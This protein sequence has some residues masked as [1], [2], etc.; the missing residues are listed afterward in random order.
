MF[1][2]F[3]N[4]AYDYE[5]QL[6]NAIKAFLIEIFRRQKAKAWNHFVLIDR[7]CK[8]DQSVQMIA[9]L[10]DSG[11]HRSYAKPEGEE[12]SLSKSVIERTTRRNNRQM[13]STNNGTVN[14]KR[15]RS[16]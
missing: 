12:R 8:N 1:Y 6:P 4:L 7:E 14:G 11:I 15:K 9:F 10:K 2:Y 5:S 13:S 16:Q 3:E